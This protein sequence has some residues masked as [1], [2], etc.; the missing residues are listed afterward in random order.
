MKKNIGNDLKE[1]LTNSYLDDMA[2]GH[3]EAWESRYKE[4]KSKKDLMFDLEMNHDD[5][6]EIERAEGDL[7]RKLNDDENAFLTTQFHKAV[8]KNWRTKSLH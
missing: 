1:L 8:S 7:Q 5:G 2:I 3:L 4:Y 6:L